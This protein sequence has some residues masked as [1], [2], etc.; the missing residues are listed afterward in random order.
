MQVN[1]INPI[2]NL[3][4]S[5]AVTFGGTGGRNSRSLTRDTREHHPTDS[6][7]ISEATR[8]SSDAGISTFTS[9]NPNLNSVRGTVTVKPIK[10]ISPTSLLSTSALLSPGS[11]KDD[12]MGPTLQ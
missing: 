1:D 4:E 8:D 12:Q 6:G 9:A 11:D 7:I 10:D 3:K 5:E 2:Q